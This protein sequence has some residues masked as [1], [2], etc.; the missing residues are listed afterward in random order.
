MR[1][2]GTVLGATLLSLAFAGDA[3]KGHGKLRLTAE[4]HRLTGA[5]TAEV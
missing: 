2:F 1:A 5:H 3:G 4:A